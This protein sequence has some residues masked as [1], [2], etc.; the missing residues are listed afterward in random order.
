M[1]EFSL[2]KW[3]ISYRYLYFF[4]DFISIITEKQERSLIFVGFLENN[5]QLD[6]LFFHVKK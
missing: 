3:G 6:L 4:I 1:F 5:L 2:L